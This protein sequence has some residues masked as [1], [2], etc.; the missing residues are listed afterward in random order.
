M[1]ADTK[2]TTKIKLLECIETVLQPMR[3]GELLEREKGKLIKSN[4]TA[5]RD[6]T[7]PLPKIRVLSRVLA[8]KFESCLESAHENSSPTFESGSSPGISSEHSR[9]LMRSRFSSLE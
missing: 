4:D 5:T 6:L 7:S 8:R 2:E 9:M 3:R 1:R